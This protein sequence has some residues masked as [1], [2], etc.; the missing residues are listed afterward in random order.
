MKGR[1]GG[2]LLCPAGQRMVVK[3]C[4]VVV[5]PSPHPPDSSSPAIGLLG[6][7]HT[8]PPHLL[9]VPFSAGMAG[10]PL[11]RINKNTALASSFH[12]TTKGPMSTSLPGAHVIE[13]LTWDYL[14]L[15]YISHFDK[16]QR[17]ESR[18]A[19][20]GLKTPVMLQSTVPEKAQFKQ[21]LQDFDSLAN[22]TKSALCNET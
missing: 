22:I 1:M 6:E 11:P 14:E 3:L 21:I 13:I 20:V 7:G 19:I 18:N 5:L 10:P 4:G 17:T 2:K 15:I 9:L 12:R 8:F 16:K